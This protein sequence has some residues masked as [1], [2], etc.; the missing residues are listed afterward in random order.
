MNKRNNRRSRPALRLSAI[1]I[2]ALAIFLPRATSA[3]A[4]TREAASTFKAM[5][6]AAAQGR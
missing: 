4:L 3:D 6:L 5:N 2:L 1:C